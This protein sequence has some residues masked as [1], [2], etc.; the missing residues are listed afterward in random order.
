M[1]KKKD[2]NTTKDCAEILQTITNSLTKKGKIKGKNKH[3]TKM[4]IYAC[5]HNKLTKKG[6]VQPTI[7]KQNG[8]LHCSMCDARFSGHI[9]SDEEVRA[10]CTK[11]MSLIQQMKFLTPALGAD[12]DT[13]RFITNAAITMESLPKIYKRIRKVAQKNKEMKRKKNNQNRGYS[14]NEGEW[15]VSSRR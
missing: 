4:L 10:M 7:D 15:R 8:K 12:K 6:K 2:F 13:Q 14:G 1:G 5:P 9:Y 3:E 11:T